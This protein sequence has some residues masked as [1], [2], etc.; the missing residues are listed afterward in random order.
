M[1]EK[2]RGSSSALEVICLPELSKRRKD[3]NYDLLDVDGIVRVGVPVF[4]G[5][6][7]VGKVVRGSKSDE[8][9]ADCS[10]VVKHNEEGIV[11]RVVVCTTLAGYKLVKV[12]IRTQKIPEVGDKF[13]SRAAQKGT[14]G[15]ILAQEDLPFTRDG[16]TPDIIINAHCI[17]SRMTINQLMETVL[18]KASALDGKYGDATPFGAKSDPATIGEDICTR[19]KSCGFEKHGY[20]T[21][22][23]GFSGEP[24]DAQIFI[25]PVMYQRLKHMVSEKIHSRN[26]GH[27]TTLTR[28]PLEGRSR[29]G[30][31]RFGE[32]ERDCMISHGVSRFLKER[33]LDQSD[34]Y[35]VRICDVC[36]NF[37]IVSTDCISCGSDKISKINMPY[38]A[39]LLIQELNTM[40][41][42]TFFKAKS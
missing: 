15:A 38:A 12:I 1:A 19:L 4:K 7:V 24:L 21:M 13:C 41:I 37:G 6:V 32:M 34:P 30:G 28:Q 26:S 23:S 18:G 16:I 29:D 17:P 9:G 10:L 36:G 35:Q 22:Y 27:V 3:A 8:G 33:L 20:E 14:C 40:G 11:D 42:K 31:L 39:K 2:K 25:G 5:D